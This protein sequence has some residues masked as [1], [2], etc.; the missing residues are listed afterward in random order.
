DV[1]MNWRQYATALVL[2]TLGCGA[3]VFTLAMLQGML[4]LNPRGVPGVPPDLAFNMAVAFISNTDWQSYS[5]EIHL[6]YLTQ[7]AAC[8]VQNFLAAATG[9]AVAVALFRAL[10]RKQTDLLGNFWADM[11]RCILYIL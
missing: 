1:E 10:A 6:S 3:M 7:M 2:F 5:G 8:T 4:P 9:M 11:V